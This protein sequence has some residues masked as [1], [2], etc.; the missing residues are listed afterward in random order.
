MRFIQK[1]VLDRDLF[2]LDLHESGDER[3]EDRDHES[4]P[5]SREESDASLETGVSPGEFDEDAVVQDDCGEHCD[6]GED[7]H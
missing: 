1:P 6:G 4:D 3:R 2:S 5:H 7:G